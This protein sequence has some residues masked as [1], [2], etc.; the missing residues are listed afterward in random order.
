MK[1]RKDCFLA[2]NK[3]IDRAATIVIVMLVVTT[4]AWILSL[5]FEHSYE[6]VN[7]YG[8][9]VEI[10]GYGIYAHDSYVK[11]PLFI[12]A[13]VTRLFCLVPLFVY[14]WL[15]YRKNGD[16]ASELSLISVYAVA[17]YYAASLCLGCFS[18]FVRYGW[19]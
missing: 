2:V 10:Y 18:I 11:A 13:D 17:L 15:R 16:A 6:F 7:Q 19:I 5:S 14:S 1:K 4:L 8:H 3:P 12:G 9:T